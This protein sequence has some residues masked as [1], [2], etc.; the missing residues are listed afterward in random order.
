MKSRISDEQVLLGHS[1]AKAVLS[2]KQRFG[3]SIESEYLAGDVLTVMTQSVQ[4]IDVVVLEDCVSDTL[5]TS[6]GVF[7]TKSIVK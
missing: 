1:R 3:T 6:D 5:E 4:R 7:N 2:L